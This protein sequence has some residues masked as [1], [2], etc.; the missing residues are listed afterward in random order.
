MM[1]LNELVATESELIIDQLFTDSRVRV[2]NGLFF[3]VK[4][5]VNDGHN[6]CDSAIASGAVAIVHSDDLKT[7]QDNITYIK[8]EDVDSA[9]NIAASK[10]YDNPSSKLSIFAVTGT[11]GKTS[12]ASIITDILN[13][14]ENTGYIGTIN[15]AYNNKTIAAKYTTPE[16]IDFHSIMADMVN[17]NVT[18]LA[19]EVSSHSLIQ[20][21]VD[22]LE[23]DYA[24]FT[25][26]SHEHLDYHGTME[27]YYFAKAKLFENLSDKQW[28]IIN[29]DDQSG[30]RLMETDIINKVSYAIDHPADYRAIDAEYSIDST[31][32]TLLYK[33]EAYE[34]ETNLVAKFN[35]SNLL[36]AI[37]ALHIHG[38]SFEELI[39]YVKDIDQISG[40]VEKIDFNNQFQVIVD[41]AHTPDGFEKLFKYAKEIVGDKRIISVFGSAGERDILKRSILGE[42]A[43]KYS[44]MIILTEDDPRN[45]SVVAISKQ[46]AEGIEQNY[47][48][49]ENRYDAIYQAIELANNGDIILVLGKGNDLYMALDSGKETYMGDVNIVREILKE[50]LQEENENE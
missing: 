26:L 30:E 8:V 13:H 9:L 7:Y 2:E 24:I 16:V 47:I 44:D 23:Y 12:V 20:R 25:N 5:I 34:F 3:C 1:K 43:D 38:L 41:Y 39:K 37:A 36:A 21:R 22:S 4:G 29:I 33:E 19:T 15:I 48:V 50:Y 35:L 17:E 14:K 27:N 18:A 45:E 28:A 49:I 46:I 11:N 10:F 32:F 42:I 31:K 6:F 40:R